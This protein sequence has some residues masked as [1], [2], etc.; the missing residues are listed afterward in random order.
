MSE[1]YMMVSILN[2]HHTKPFLTL[3]QE[4][5]VSINFIT[6]ARGTAASEMLDTFG[7]ESHEKVL[8]SSIVTHDVWKQIRRGLQ[9]KLKIDIPGKGIAFIV[10]LSSIGGRRQLEFLTADQ[11]YVK[12]EES[13]LKDTKYELLIVIANQGYTDLIMSAARKANAGG[14]T[15]IH[16][17]GTGMDGAEKFLGFSLAAEKDMVYIVAKKE[18]KNAIMQAIMQDAGMN[19]KAKSIIFSLPVTSTAGMRLAELPTE[20]EEE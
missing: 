13:I 9:D 18:E 19:S 16:A 8:V 3:Y 7:L 1:L 5:G 15:I 12:G 11:N 2:R 14:G 6:L 17:K 4:H 10:P 20:G